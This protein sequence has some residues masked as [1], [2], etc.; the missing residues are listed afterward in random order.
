[1]N[2]LNLYKT[3]LKDRDLVEIEGKESL[4]FLQNLITNDT[5]LINENKAIY[6]ALLTP[7]G[8]YLFDFILFLKAKNNDKILIDCE[9]AR[10]DELIKTFNVYKLR[11]KVT[12][13][14]LKNIKFY[15]IFGS[16]SEQLLSRIG[17]KNLE[18]YSI[19]S[20]ENVAFFDPRNKN[21]GIRIITFNS[22][23]PRYLKNIPSTSNEEWDLNRIALCIPDGS[24]DME[25]NKS[26]LIE[27]NFENLNGID[28]DKGCYLGQ[29]NTARQK[30]RAN[31]KK[32]LYKV[33]IYG[34]PIPNGTDIANEN[35]IVG[36]MRSSNLHFGL[37]T[38][39]IDA[40]NQAKKND[41]KLKAANSYIKII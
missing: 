35:K 16:I 32:R 39:K 11:K 7:Q 36:I 28:F 21:L 24:K 27:N 14:K 8:K 37:A 33:K 12:I 22:D 29:E 18:G 38:L 23:Q 9:K 2:K 13:S 15:S 30:Y 26:F 17:L 31:L 19:T 1:M 20:E 10:S 34:P 5:N 6:S 4:D 3:H 40:A 25:I 41:K